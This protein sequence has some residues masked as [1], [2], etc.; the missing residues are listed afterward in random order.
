MAETSSLD[1]SSCSLDALITWLKEEAPVVPSAPQVNQV[2]RR[3]HTENRDLRPFKIAFVRND[4]IEPFFPYLVYHSA[5]TGLNL[6]TWAS[7]YADWHVLVAEPDSSLWQF[8]PEL[9]VISL[10]LET[11]APELTHRF[12]TTG[13]QQLEEATKR[14]LNELTTLTEEIRHRSK[15]WILVQNFIPI[16]DPA[17][18]VYDGQATVGQNDLI[19]QLNRD[20]KARVNSISGT[21]LFD[22]AHWSM[23]VGLE[24]IN[25]PR[26]SLTM[27]VPFG[28]LALNTLAVE[29]LRYLR[30]LLG[31]R[32]KCL[33]LDLDNTL[34]G[35]V[36]GED[37][38]EGIQIGRTYPGNAYRAFQQAILDLFHRGVILA[39]CSKNNEQEALNAIE[40][41]PDMLL[42]TEHFASLRINWKDKATNLQEIAAE[43]NIGLDSLVFLDDN[44]SERMLVRQMRPEILTLDLP[45]APVDYAPFARRITE[46]E[47]LTLSAEDRER[48]TLYRVQTERRRLEQTTSSLEDYYASLEMRLEFGTADSFAATR[49][50]QLTQK[51]NQFNLTTHR[52]GEHEIS[53]KAKDPFWRVFW[54]RV[55]DRFGDNGIVGVAIL[56]ELIPN[57]WEIDT[58]LLSCRVLGRSVESAFLS[59]LLIQIKSAGGQW[60]QGWFKPTVKNTPANGFYS[61]HGF[62]LRKESGNDTLWEC[63]LTQKTVAL[64]P[65]FQVTTV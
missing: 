24:Q 39:I 52:Y 4:T 50:A 60:A 8:S 34:W 30:P 28:R 48:G 32:R 23:R 2:V 13:V 44:P 25:D 16:A 1:I 17:F 21:Y 61:K 35:G 53:D 62:T 19:G 41:H 38:Y 29:Y 51:T 59:F 57:R 22:Y 47:A 43:L 63:D 14:V 12:A 64:P 10:S 56:H 5:R 55:L 27:G 40:H 58:L 65:W 6:K 9:I 31:Q 15:A 54:V 7:G 36:L 45:T 11:L 18:G 26:L 3:L 20:L 37:G 42:R 49:I 46:F 33:V